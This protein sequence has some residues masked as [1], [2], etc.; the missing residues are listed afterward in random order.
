MTNCFRRLPAPAQGRISRF[1]VAGNSSIEIMVARQ[2]SYYTPTELGFCQALFSSRDTR[3][4]PI[5]RPIEEIMRNSRSSNCWQHSSSSSSRWKTI[6]S[7][8]KLDLS[9]CRLEYLHHYIVTSLLH[10]CALLMKLLPRFYAL[11]VK[12]LVNVDDLFHTFK[13]FHCG[14]I[15]SHFLHN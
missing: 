6:L 10:L 13:G 4:S 14:L 9:L 8:P 2:T 5:N 7:G 12:L 11:L 3:D 1:A 15:Q